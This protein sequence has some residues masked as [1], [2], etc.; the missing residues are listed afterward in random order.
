MKTKKI[1]RRMDDALFQLQEAQA[2]LEAVQTGQGARAIAERMQAP[3]D[4]MLNILE[5]LMDKMEKAA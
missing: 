1:I 5:R 3:L 4:E 2:M